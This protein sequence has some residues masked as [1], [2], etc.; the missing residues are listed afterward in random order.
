MSPKER[1]KTDKN[2]VSG[3]NDSIDSAKMQAAFDAAML[4]MISGLSIAVTPEQAVANHYRVEGAQKFLNTL[5]NLNSD[6]TAKTRVDTG[7]LTHKTSLCQ[8]LNPHHPPSPR[9]RTSIR[10]SRDW[11]PCSLPMLP[12]EKPDGIAPAGTPAGEKG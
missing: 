11:T 12:A 2:L 6:T 4:E 9:R 1:F 5:K 3:F 7:N 8:P 10:P